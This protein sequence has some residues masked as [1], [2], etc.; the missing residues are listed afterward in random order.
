MSPT[1]ANLEDF[2]LLA[3]EEEFLEDFELL[4]DEEE[5]FYDASM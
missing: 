2:D 3:D 5:E 1:N 4:A